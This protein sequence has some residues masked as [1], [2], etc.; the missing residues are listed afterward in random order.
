MAR[1]SLKLLV[2]AP[3]FTRT[4]MVLIVINAVILGMETYPGIMGAYGG[5]VK[6]IV[7]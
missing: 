6:A 5:T 2:E 3:W 7:T 1:L 4:I